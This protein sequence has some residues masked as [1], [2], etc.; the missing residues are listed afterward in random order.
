MKTI[1]AFEAKT[2][3]AQ[4][5]QAASEGETFLITRRGVR[6]ARLVM[7][8][9]PEKHDLKQVVRDLRE[10]RKEA[11]L[12]GATLRELIDEGRRY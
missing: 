7:A 2:H 1:G 9:Q 12:N 4:L 8:D 10:I 5:L 3:L 6:L 11:R